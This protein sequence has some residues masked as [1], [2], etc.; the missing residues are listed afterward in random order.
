MSHS[1]PNETFFAQAAAVVHSIGNVTRKSKSGRVAVATFKA[2]HLLVCRAAYHSPLPIDEPNKERFRQIQ[3][4]GDIDVSAEVEMV[5][6]AMI[7]MQNRHTPERTLIKDADASAL[8]R[9]SAR[10]ASLPDLVIP[11]DTLVSAF[12]RH[13]SFF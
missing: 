4:R 11:Q 9:K 1:E 8:Q 7:A 6:R 10:L 12:C 3:G 13:L 2:E 5:V